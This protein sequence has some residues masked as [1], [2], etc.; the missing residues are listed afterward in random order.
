MQCVVT[1]SAGQLGRCLVDRIQR[2]ANHQL[3]WAPER[4][5]FDL[6]D[7]DGLSSIFGAE[8][9][10]GADV[11]FNAAAYTAV[12][13]CESE[14]STALRTNGL[15]PGKLAAR[16][17][18]HGVRFVHVSTDYVFGGDHHSP[19]PHD[20]PTAPRTAYGRTK[21][22][23]EEAVMAEA[24]DSLIVRTSWV[25]GPGKNFVTAILE[26]ARK[27][28]SGEIEGPL[29]VVAD[30]TGSPT[31]ADHLAGGL[32]EL[33][34]RS[35]RGMTPGIYHLAGEGETTWWGFAR[36]ILD[37]TGHADLEIER[38]RTEDLNV[39]AARPAYSVLDTSRAAAQGVRL[40]RWQD[41][42]AG[43][44]KSLHPATIVEG[45]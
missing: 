10:Q 6:D 25:F 28:R 31:Y 16:C 14:E 29:S 42:L 24:P 1:G 41:G 15:A 8:R 4:A 13:R 9:G 12:D 34:E 17:R 26:Q 38:T 11:L 27:R 45:A 19:Y 7:L 18:A 39:A 40:A 2:S 32:I 20:A 44:L 37:E 35:E 33:V 21:L 43:Y 23:G 3:V 22:A 36:R 5:A 30:Q